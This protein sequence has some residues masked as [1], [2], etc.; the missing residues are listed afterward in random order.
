MDFAGTSG[1]VRGGINSPWPFSTSAAYAATRLVLDRAIPNSGGYFRAVRGILLNESSD[2]IDQWSFAKTA[3]FAS[4]QA[5]KKLV[6]DESRQ[7]LFGVRCVK[8]FARATKK[9][10]ENDVHRSRDA[11]HDDADGGAGR[12]AREPDGGERSGQ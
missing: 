4:S 5:F 10:D 1:Q 3:V 6:I 2:L 9:T 8:R 7:L 11:A 12:C